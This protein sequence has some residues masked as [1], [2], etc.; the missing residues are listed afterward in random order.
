M[1]LAGKWRARRAPVT[2][3]SR[4][5]AAKGSKERNVK[6]IGSALSIV[7]RGAAM[8]VGEPRRQ[9]DRA[10]AARVRRGLQDGE[11]R[12]AFQPVIHA[13][14][15]RLSGVECLLRWQHPDYGLLLPGS[16]IQALDDPR[17]ARAASRFV[18]ESACQQLRT[19][20]DAGHPLPRVSVNIHPSQLLDE[21]LCPTIQSLTE[22]YGIDPSLIELE[23]VETADASKL[24]CIGEITRSLRELGVRIAIDG[25]GSGYASLAVLSSAQID[26]IKLAREFLAKVPTSHRACTVMSCVLDMLDK[27]EIKVVIEGVETEA[28]LRWLSRRAE[29]HAQG[30]HIARPQTKFAAA[31]AL[32]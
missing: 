9:N 2:Q 20:Q 16:F 1:V 29:V 30:Y 26:T 12:V 10:L 25:F 3:R 23:L 11:F 32:N 21:D 24:L 22:H 8:N 18:L 6:N 5:A 4:P 13:Q 27:L 14:T 31:I 19:I 7:G 17:T 15:S 28:Q